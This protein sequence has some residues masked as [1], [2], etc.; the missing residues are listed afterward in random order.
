[1]IAVHAFVAA[2]FVFEAALHLSTGTL[3]L[4]GIALNAFV[5]VLHPFA[6]TLR[7]TVGSLYLPAVALHPSTASPQLHVVTPSPSEVSLPGTG[8]KL[9]EIPV[10]NQKRDGAA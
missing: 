10:Q 6:A 1:M 4:P 7:L 8:E 3:C 5:V 9:R 2:V